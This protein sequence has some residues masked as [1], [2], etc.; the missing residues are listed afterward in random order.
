MIINKSSG[1]I[2]ISYELEFS[3]PL[4]INTLIMGGGILSG[5]RKLANWEGR[6]NEDVLVTIIVVLCD[7]N[8][9]TGDSVMPPIQV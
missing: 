7:I 5:T 2:F 3:V 6:F 4:F 1:W 9:L 8:W